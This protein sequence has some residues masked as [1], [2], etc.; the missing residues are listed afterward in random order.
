[1]SVLVKPTNLNKL[2]HKQHST[3][4]CLKDNLFPIVNFYLGHQWGNLK[5]AI[6]GG[7]H[8]SLTCGWKDGI[9]AS[10]LGHKKGEAEKEQ[11]EGKAEEAKCQKAEKEDSWF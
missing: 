1:M 5:W 9:E 11:G 7:A 6:Q 2:N 4:V 10:Y 8:C 3:C